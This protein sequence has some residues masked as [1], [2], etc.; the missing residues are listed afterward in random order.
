MFVN[1]QARESENLQFKDFANAKE[2]TKWFKSYNHSDDHEGI[3]AQCLDFVP[4]G[5][6]IMAIYLLHKTVKTTD[7][8]GKERISHPIVYPN[9]AD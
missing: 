9:D 5:D 8:N 7:D 4:D 6:G 3:S 2:L 1:L